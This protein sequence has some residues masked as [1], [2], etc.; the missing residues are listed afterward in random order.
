MMG[1][2]IAVKSDKGIIIGDGAG[3]DIFLSA[4]SLKEGDQLSYYVADIMTTKP[5]QFIVE[6]HG[7]NSISIDD[8]NDSKIFWLDPS[9]KEA[10]KMEM[11]MPSLGGAK[12]TMVK[13]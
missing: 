11:L 9:T 8:E 2:E 5:K 6:H 1:K 12:V 3:Y 13:K 4:L 10:I 7:N